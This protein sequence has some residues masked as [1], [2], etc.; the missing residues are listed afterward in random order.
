MRETR[1]LT[2]S[3]RHAGRPRTKRTPTLEEALLEEV[4]ENLNISI[5]NL[6]HNLHVNNSLIQRILKQE[7]Y[8]PYLYTKFRH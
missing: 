4:D 1:N 8:Y 3:H 5:R 6:V 2:P 7:K